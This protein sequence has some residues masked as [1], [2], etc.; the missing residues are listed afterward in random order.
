MRSP[1]LRLWL[2]PVFGRSTLL[3][4]FQLSKARG[5]RLVEAGGGD[6]SARD[7]YF[8]LTACIIRLVR[9]FQ[10]MT[11]CDEEEALPEFRFSGSAQSVLEAHKASGAILIMPHSTGAILAASELAKHYDVLM[12]VK[13]QKDPRRAAKQHKFYETLECETLDARRADPVT[14]ARTL[15]KALKSKRMVIGTCDRIKGRPRGGLDHHKE[16]DTVLCH[17]LGQEIG[18]VGWPARFAQK[19]GIPM[20]PLMPI[21]E[22]DC[23]E[24][25]LG[26]PIAATGDI[27][28]D[29]PAWL[30]AMWSLFREHPEHWMFVDDNQR[31]KLLL[32]AS[33]SP[34]S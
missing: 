10:A 7:L 22:D 31:S 9:T 21:F 13:E 6:V 20:I 27:N 33:E 19:C 30:D 4:P 32:K 15:M 2:P 23:V 5:Q 11:R 34:A 3:P 24:L 8:G 18:V 28:V 16:S 1:W 14:L 12:L 29:S 26:E 17:L 25:Y